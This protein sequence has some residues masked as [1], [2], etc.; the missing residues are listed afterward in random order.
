MLSDFRYAFRQLIKSPGFTLVAVLTLALGIGACTA[1]FSVVNGVLL[2]PLDFPEPERLVVLRE[3]QLPDFPEFSLSP[4]NYLDWEKQTTSFASMAAYTGAPLNFTGDIEPQRLIGVKVTA[5]YFDVYGVKPILGRALLPEEDKPGKEHVVVIS[6][7]FWQRAFAGESSVL[8]RPLQLNGEPYTVVGVAPAGFG[9]ASKVDAWVPMAFRPDDITE[10]NRG[11]HYLSAIG[12]LKPGVTVAQADAELKVLSAQLAKQYVKSNKGWGAFA[13]PLLDYT[14]RDVRRALY[15]LLGAVGCVLLIACANIANLLLARATA[16]SR[17]ISIRAALGAGRARLVRQLLTESVVLALL[18]GA[19]G[20]LLA[21][22]GLDALLALAPASLPR[23][24]GIQLDASVLAGSMAL[25]LATGVIFGLAPAWMAARADVNEALKQGTR[26]STEGG[27]QGRLRSTLVVL[28]V[29]ASLVLLAGAGLLARSFVALAHVDPGFTPEHATVMR[30]TLPSKK[31]SKPEQKFAFADA[32]IAKLAALPGVQA[33]GLTHSMPLLGDYVLGFYVEGRQRPDDADMPNTN[34][35][36][37]TPD[38]FRAMGI[39]LVRGRLFTARDNATAPRVALINETLARQIFPNE[40]PIGKRIGIT[41]GPDAWREIVGV[42]SD[43]KQYGVDRATTN[44]SYE[45]FA[46]VPFTSLN[47]VIRTVGEPAAMLGAL[48]PAV[49][50]TDK[51]QPVGSVRPLEDIMADSISRQRFMMTL[52]SVFSLVALLIAAVGIYGVM[53]YNVTQRTSE[54]GIR[55]ALGAQPGDVLRLVFAQGGKL[56]GLGLLIG[57]LTA[58]A[59]ARA[60]ESILFNTS[61][62]DPLTLAGITLLLAAVAAVACLLPARRAA[63][64]DPIVALR[65]E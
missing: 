4:P 33:V 15:M 14:V 6:Q 38:Y 51:D 55:M 64:V 35:Y 36:S 25:S 65:A 62:H 19:A 1:I 63:R 49:Y 59:S 48:R 61:A 34:Y 57:L 40:D 30:L 58:L 31:Y 18:G 32:L 29:A 26:G 3:T 54:I 12:R 46:Q 9:S 56:V 2:R 28:E 24:S 22:W 10:D 27:A 11:S 21:R 53:A 7:A 20:I 50:A 44:Q 37:V 42:V 45:P 60:V 17:E 52:L 8:G 16:R 41:N 23:V 13:A 39:R 43:I 47:V 5:H